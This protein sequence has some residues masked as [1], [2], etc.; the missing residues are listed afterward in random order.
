MR[1]GRYTRST[2][3]RRRAWTSA[4]SP[5]RSWRSAPIAPTTCGS[6][7]SS[8]SGWRRGCLRRS[9]LVPLASLRGGLERRLAATE[10]GELVVLV[11]LRRGHEAGR[12]GEV[13]RARRVGLL[14]AV[15]VAVEAFDRSERDRPRIGVRRRVGVASLPRRTLGSPQHRAAVD[16]RH[17]RQVVLTRPGILVAAL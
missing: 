4:R 7:A 6:T 15:R 5:P 12:L 17:L 2:S 3:R 13:A 8:W 11:Q 16:H 14:A 9:G 10:P 1:T